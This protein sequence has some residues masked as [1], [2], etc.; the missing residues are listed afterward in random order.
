MKLWYLI[1]PSNFSAKRL[2]MNELLAVIPE[3]NYFFQE[4]LHQE[5]RYFPFYAHRN[6]T[7]Y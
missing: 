5:N 7:G 2:F 3:L 6:Y 1:R 4:T